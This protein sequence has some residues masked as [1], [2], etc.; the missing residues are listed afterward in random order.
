MCDLSSHS[1]FVFDINLNFPFL[2]GPQRGFRCYHCVF[3]QDAFFEKI[4]TA[5]K[6]RPRLGALLIPC[7]PN[8]SIQLLNMHLCDLLPTWAEFRKKKLSQRGQNQR[9]RKSGPILWVMATCQAWGGGDILWSWGELRASFGGFPGSGLPCGVGRAGGAAASC[10][11]VQGWEGSALLSS[12]MRCPLLRMGSKETGAN[13]QVSV[14]DPDLP[15]VKSPYQLCLL[16]LFDVH[17]FLCYFMK[18]VGCF[19]S[20]STRRPAVLYWQLSLAFITKRSHCVV[21]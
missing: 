12:L 6:W 18:H 4:S 16:S 11:V 5:G 2:L 13:H 7:S 10:L 19:H 15:E 8:N 20:F 14:G 21:P 9:V 17:Q 3:Y 1:H